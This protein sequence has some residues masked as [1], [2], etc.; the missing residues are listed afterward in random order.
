VPATVEGNPLTAEMNGPSDLV[1][2][3]ETGHTA[4]IT[5]YDVCQSGGV[6]Q[7][8]DRVLLPNWRR[9]SGS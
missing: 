3:D 6:I 1:V 5:I 4:R 7:V 2:M 8:I 9:C